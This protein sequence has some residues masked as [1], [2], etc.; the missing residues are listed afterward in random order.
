MHGSNMASSY[1]EK[2]RQDKSFI[3]FPRSFDGKE[4]A[5]NKKCKN[6]FMRINTQKI[7]LAA[8]KYNRI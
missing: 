6:K 8:I 5:F 1:F 3:D 2:K 4:M 7:Q